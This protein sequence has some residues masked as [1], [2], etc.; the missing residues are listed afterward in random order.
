MV[1]DPIAD[2][3][4]RLRNASRA[5]H[6]T[7]SIPASKS[8]ERVLKVLRAQGFVDRVEP[9]DDA[10]GKRYLKIFLRYGHGGRPAIREIKRLSK[11]GQR[12]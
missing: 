3:L 1:T 9:F 2:L 5:G 4:T 11:P 7:V 10:T 12:V 6:P 8:K